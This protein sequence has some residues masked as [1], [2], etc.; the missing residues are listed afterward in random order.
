[1]LHGGA[2]VS[3]VLLSGLAVCVVLT[4]HRRALVKVDA[5]QEATYRMEEV[6]DLL[7]VYWVSRH[8]LPASLH[9]LV[10]SCSGEQENERQMRVEYLSRGG[11]ACEKINDTCVV[12]S[13]PGHNRKRDLKIV[14]RV[15]NGEDAAAYRGFFDAIKELSSGDDLVYVYDAKLRI[16]VRLSWFYRVG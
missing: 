4:P 11:I 9:D 5:E 2:T 6:L 1:M 16:I 7:D 15:G 12:V 3:F 8:E 10:F 14:R 13:Y